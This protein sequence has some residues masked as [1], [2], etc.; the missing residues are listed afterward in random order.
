MRR[1]FARSKFGVLW[2]VEGDAFRAVTLHNAPPAFAEERRRNPVVRP[3]PGQQ[4]VR[5]ARTKD[6]VHIPDLLAD[7][8]A[9]PV[10]AKLTGARALLTVP[11]LKENELIGAI[12]IYR[13]K[14]G[15]SAR[16]KSSC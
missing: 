7:E 10:L 5:L 15:R 11:M 12:V 9:A 14:S 3:G 4:L 1:A 6:V 2:L 8:A 16:S 13:F